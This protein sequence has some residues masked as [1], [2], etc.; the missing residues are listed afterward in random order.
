MPQHSF[1]KSTRDHVRLHNAP[2]PGQYDGNHGNVKQRDP[3]FSFGAGAGRKDM[4]TPVQPGPGSYNTHPKIGNEGPKYSAGSRPSRPMVH[5][6]GALVPGPGTYNHSE[7]SSHKYSSA[8]KFNFGRAS[9]DSLGNT[10]APGPGQYSPIDAQRPNSPRHGFGSAGRSNSVPPKQINPGP[11][12]YI[13]AERLG[14]EGVKFSVGLKPRDAP[15]L[16]SPGPGAYDH[17]EH[18]G[19][20]LSPRYGFGTSRRNSTNSKVVN[21]GPGTYGEKP[22]DK[23]RHHS[24]GTRTFANYDSRTPG[25]GA[26]DHTSMF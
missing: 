24:F 20:Q 14:K 25:P 11:G 2:G 19:Q 6:S 21:P 16:L 3:Q 26:H 9:R 1:G 8:P 15:V 5:R 22:L 4:P 17:R 18:P 7:A 13:A 12:T 10:L 23:G